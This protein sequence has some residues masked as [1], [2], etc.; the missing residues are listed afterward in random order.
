MLKIEIEN[1]IEM[2]IEENM[3][4]T[5]LKRPPFGRGLNTQNISIDRDYTILHPQSSNHFNSENILFT[6]VTWIA[7]VVL[8][9]LWLWTA[10]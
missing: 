4:Q 2:E 8:S 5:K 3:K 7:T 9:I 10:P 6:G 1:E